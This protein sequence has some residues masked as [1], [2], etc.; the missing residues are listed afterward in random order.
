MRNHLDANSKKMVLP[1]IILMHLSDTARLA[2]RTT[3]A[4]DQITLEKICAIG[5]TSSG[6]DLGGGQ[7]MPLIIQAPPR[8]SAMRYRKKPKKSNAKGIESPMK[9]ERNRS[10]VNLN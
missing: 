1:K 5:S 4:T 6:T 7:M 9:K 3:M 10:K 2:E 8:A